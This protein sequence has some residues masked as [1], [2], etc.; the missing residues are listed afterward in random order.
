MSVSVLVK[1]QAGRHISS[2]ISIAGKGYSWHLIELCDIISSSISHGL[3]GQRQECSTTSH[4]MKYEINAKRQR[5]TRKWNLDVLVGVLSASRECEVVAN[6]RIVFHVFP[7]YFPFSYYLWVEG[8]LRV[9]FSC[10]S[11]KSFAQILIKMQ[12]LWKGGCGLGGLIFGIG[13]C[14]CHCW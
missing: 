10:I 3:L 4:H 11:C 5:K 6:S 12:F 2:I 14:H 9:G 1:L 13:C 7:R 8:S